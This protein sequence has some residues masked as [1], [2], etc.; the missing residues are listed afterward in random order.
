MNAM[1]H[2]VGGVL[3]QNDPQLL[4]EAEGLKD[5]ARAARPPSLSPVMAHL[6]TVPLFTAIGRAMDA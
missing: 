4:M 2:T 6:I 3:T 1:W 5:L